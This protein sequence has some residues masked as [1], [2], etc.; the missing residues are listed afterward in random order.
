MITISKIIIV[1][2]INDNNNNNNNNNNNKEKLQSSFISI[3]QILRP[4]RKTIIDII[5]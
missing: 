1:T 3:H 5:F 4:S 2:S